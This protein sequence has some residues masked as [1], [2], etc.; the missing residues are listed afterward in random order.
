MQPIGRDSQ[1]NSIMKNVLGKRN[2]HIWRVCLQDLLWD[3]VST[4]LS[5]EEIN[6]AHKFYTPML[7]HRYKRCRAAL[8]CILAMYLG[9]DPRSLGFTYNQFGKPELVDV[10]LHFNV[11]HSDAEALIAVSMHLVGVDLETDDGRVVDISALSNWVCHSNEK[12]K[13]ALMPQAQR[14]AEF[15]RLW[16]YKEAYGKALG[17]GLRCDFR[18]IKLDP[19]PVGSISRVINITRS[20]AQ[21][22]F[23]YDLSKFLGCASS[24]CLPMSK[25]E[26]CISWAKPE[27]FRSITSSVY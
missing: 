19:F 14:L 27:S 2:V 15:Y 9:Q 25:V 17:V 4:V 20:D 8:R 22:Y 3:T 18:D 12:S 26:I 6:K 10:P 13:L 21:E 5:P 24:V 16:T 1:E 23:A 7:Q 11:S